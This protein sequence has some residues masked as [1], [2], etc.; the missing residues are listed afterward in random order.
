MKK[1]VKSKKAKATRLRIK[2]IED[3]KELVIDRSK[4]G[5]GDAG[6]YL[7][8]P[9][10]K[11]QCCLGFACRALGFPVRVIRMKGLPRN[12]QLAYANTLP[13]WMRDR[14]QNKNAFSVAVINDDP[15]I[16]QTVREERVAVF[17]A[18][19]GIKVKFIGEFPKRSRW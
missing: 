1:T 11:L 19:H 16:M 9:D 13:A 3:L 17:F 6:G 5:V 8:D 10:T 7:Y 15:G 4:W 12:V 14:A 18:Q 2:N